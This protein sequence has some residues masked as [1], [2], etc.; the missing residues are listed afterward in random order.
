MESTMNSC[1]VRDPLDV[2]A[3]KIRA[4]W[5]RAEDQRLAAALLLR[6]AKE[7]VEAGEDPRFVSFPVWCQVHLPGRSSR[8]IRRLIKI[9]NAPDPKSALDDLRVKTR[10]QTRR[11]RNKPDSRESTMP[12]ETECGASGNEPNETASASDI[13]EQ[14]LGCLGERLHLPLADRASMVRSLADNL[15]VDAAVVQHPECANSQDNGGR[16]RPAATSDWQDVIAQ[17]SLAVYPNTDPHNDQEPLWWRGGLQSV[18][19]LAQEASILEHLPNSDRVTD[20]T[21]RLIDALAPAFLEAAIPQ[22]KR[23]KILRL[24]LFCGYRGF[25]DQLVRRCTEADEAQAR[26]NGTQLDMFSD[27]LA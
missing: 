1:E 17:A 21:L 25:V 27:A 4:L 3:G 18:A 13:F 16:D 24:L 12:S 23:E 9:A 15:G 22:G 20:L 5:Q 14:L 8:D 10:E 19:L 26:R 2:V 11:W 7:R 6:E